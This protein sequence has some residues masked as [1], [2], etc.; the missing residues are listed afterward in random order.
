MGIWRRIFTT[1][2]AAALAFFLRGAVLASDFHDTKG[3]WA[4]EAIGRAC[5]DGYLAGFEDGSFRPDEPVTAAQ[6]L[7]ILAKALELPEP[8]AAPQTAAA[9]EDWYCEAVQKAVAAGIIDGD[10]TAFGEP[11]TRL[12]VF[13]WTARAFGFAPA[14]TDESALDGFS[15]ASDL[16]G[17]DRAVVAGLAERELVKGYKNS[18]RLSA[19]VT[20][21]EFMVFLY[22]M[23]DFNEESWAAWRAEQ[24]A[25][26]EA[27]ALEDERVL[28]LVNSHY[29]GDYTQAW[30]EAHDYTA[31]EKERW[32]R[33]KAYDSST[34]Y[35]LWV[36]ITHQRLNVFGREAG[37]WR[38]ERC[39]LVGTGAPGYGTPQGVW[40]VTY[41][42]ADGWTT[43][44]YTVSPVVGFKGGGYAFHS[45]LRYPGTQTV[46]DPAIGFPVSHGC[47]RMFQEDIDWLY[48]TIPVGTTVVVY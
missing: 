20:R 5:A 15:D 39:F 13:L 21:A 10:F 17:A 30:A 28:A 42:N 31:E 2:L 24:A 45:R 34:D 40:K 33:L 29:S 32:V 47:V 43:S 25:L 19:P 27:E 26:A 22:R 36:S 41:K 9:P 6:I 48:D 16:S 11:M 44:A 12:G 7:T 46:S 1:A 38:L 3:H 37:N 8:S 18:L 4:Q 14:E 23:A 35:L